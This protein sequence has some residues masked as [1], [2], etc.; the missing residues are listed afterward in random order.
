VEQT[1]TASLRGASLDELVVASL[2]VHEALSEPTRATITAFGE[3]DVDGASAAGETVTLEIA[4]DGTPVRYFHLVVDEIRF[5]GIHRGHE[6]RYVIQLVHGIA[7]LALRADVRM[8]Q[9]KDAQ[10][11]VQET[12]EGAGLAPDGFS[13]SIERT[14]EKRVYCV[15][16]RE[17]D[18]AFVSRLL[19]HEG[20]FYVITHDDS[21]SLLTLADSPTVFEPIGPDADLHL[22][23]DDTHGGGILEFAVESRAVP[24]MVALGD[25]NFM[26]P[27]L[28]LVSTAEVVPRGNFERFEFPT[29]HQTPDEGETLAKLRVEE[30]LVQKTQGRGK[31]DRLALRPGT[32]FN[33]TGPSREGLAQEYTLIQVDHTLVLVGHEASAAGQR[34]PTYQNEFVCIPK[35]TVYRPPRRTPA[36]RIRGAHAAVVTGPGGGEI[37]TEELGRMK[38][39]LFWDRVGPDDDKSSCWMRVGQ[40]P[41]SGSMALARM[42]WEM[43]IVYPFGDP[44]RPTAV[45]R[46]YNAEK[47]SPYAYPGA[48]SKTAFQT[49]SS[50]GGGKSNEVRMSDGS[51]GQELFL[52]ASK[53]YDG[54]TNNNKTE[55]IGGDDSRKVGVDSNEKVGANQSVTIGANLTTTVGADSGATIG[56]SRTKTVG[57]SE[58]ASVS[59]NVTEVIHGSDTEVTGGTHTTLAALGI[60]RTTVGA[61]SLTVGGSMISAAAQEVSMAVA[62]A[63]SETVGAAKIVA[64]GS[65]ISQSAIG[66]LA[67]TVG[68]V[69]VQAAGGNYSGGTKGPSVLTVGGVL[70]ANAAGELTMKAPKISVKVAGVANFLG[71]G[72]ILTLTAGSASFTG[73]VKCDAS[74]S[75]KISGNP[76]LVG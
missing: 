69:C 67:I 65:S 36:P 19:E 58:T 21:K 30:L 61:M 13:F 47:V 48:A 51:G 57:G 54:T 76:N 52:N 12:L 59:G 3:V 38:G 18:F 44:D 34:G 16:Y 33:L 25:F 68:G 46:M 31:S 74:G 50:P 11:I 45:A 72:G 26:Q 71:G 63:K 55:K 1:I 14:P 9:E 53:D 62:G 32:T 28:D 60:D 10:Q 8:F 22:M 4:V 41:I 43:A 49:P 75:L 17:T 42:G 7:H 39:K 64:A 70:C 27:N 66:A 20:I 5:D 56:G 29:G 6:R 15:Q 2:T 40:L 73:L 24:Q 35:S 23:D 37:H